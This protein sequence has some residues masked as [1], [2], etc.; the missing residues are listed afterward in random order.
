MVTRLFATRSIESACQEKGSRPVFS[1]LQLPSSLRDREKISLGIA[2]PDFRLSR[3]RIGKFDSKLVEFR[4][5]FR[6]VLHL[7]SERLYSRLVD[8]SFL[9]QV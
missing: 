9:G 8:E 1:D 3:F 6:P 7:D 5:G 4:L 2:D